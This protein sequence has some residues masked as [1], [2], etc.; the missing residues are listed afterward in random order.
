V[1]LVR[2]IRKGNYEGG[3]VREKKEENEVE[4]GKRYSTRVRLGRGKLQIRK[5][6]KLGREKRKTKW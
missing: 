4:G 2:G 3:K 5:G 6:E 1:K